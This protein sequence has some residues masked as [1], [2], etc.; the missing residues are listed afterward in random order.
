MGVSQ[1]RSCGRVKRRRYSVE[2]DGEFFVFNSIAEVERFLIQVRE[3]ADD[4]ADELVTTPVTPKPPRIR[5]KTGAGK[6]TTSVVIQRE[7]KR[8]QK[9]VN[10]AFREAAKRRAVDVEIS[11][12][13]QQKI[14][15]EDEEDIIISLLLLS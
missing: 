5:V 11:Q 1:S 14:E 9:R 4:Q 12:L 7:V 15:Q 6:P 2:I 3:T 8:T 10:K 13:L